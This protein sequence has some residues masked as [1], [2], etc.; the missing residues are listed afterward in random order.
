MARTTTTKKQTT[1]KTVSEQSAQ[2]ETSP[3]PETPAVEKQAP[4]KTSKKNK[5]EETEQQPV[6]EEKTPAVESVE[7]VET[8]IQPETLHGDQAV[9]EMTVDILSKVQ[10]L[11]ML[12]SS[13]KS[14]FKQLEKKYQKDLK[15]AQKKSIKKKRNN[16]DRAPSGF[17]KP[18]RIS[19]ELADFL[20]KEHGT[21][22]ARTSV[23]RY[24][25]NYVKEHNL[26]DVNNGRNIIPDEKLKVLLK[27]TPEDKLS[28]FNLQKY[29]VCHFAKT[30]KAT[31]VLPETPT[32]SVV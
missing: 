8:E 30:V 3:L 18:T 2:L 16:G 19:D 1:E 20:G 15:I 17:V 27:L 32:V 31:S 11:S 10:Q 6:S 22:M 7:T 12:V 21:E 29:M 4:K 13:L 25:T 9:T 26:Q 24:I 23:T 28:Y 5:K 14:D